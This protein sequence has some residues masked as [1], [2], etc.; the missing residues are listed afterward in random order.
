M[1]YSQ[2]TI[3]VT[4]KG[5]KKDVWFVFE[6][7]HETLQQQIQQLVDDGYLSGTRYE[8]RPAGHNGDRQVVNSYAAYIDRQIVISV[9]DLQ[10]K[11]FDQHG[12]ALS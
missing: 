7:P 12:R 10:S 9:T 4:N 5:E 1:C 11:L 6:T 2:V 3:T 8:T